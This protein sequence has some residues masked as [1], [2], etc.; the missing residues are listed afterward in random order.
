[1]ARDYFEFEADGY[2]QGKI[3]WSSSTNGPIQNSSNV[4]A[5]LYA[6]RTNS[7]TTKGR[8]WSGFVKINSAQSNISF[9][10]S[11]SVGSDWVEMTRV[12]TVVRHEDTGAGSAIISGSV[13]GPTETTLE[14]KTSSGKDTVTLDNILRYATGVTTTVIEFD[15][16]TAKIKWRADNVC[17][18]I[19][20]GLSSSNMTEY[21]VDSNTG[22][23]DLSGLS[24]DT[25][26]TL[27]FNAKRKDSELYLPDNVTLKFKTQPIARLT[28]VPN[29][30]IGPPIVVDPSYN[31]QQIIEWTN[32]SGANL[33]L[34]LC[35][36]DDT[37]IE[38]FGVV[39]GTTVT[40]SPNDTTILNLTPNSNVYKAKYV[41]TSVQ[42]EQTYTDEKECNFIVINSNPSFNSAILPYGGVDYVD[43]NET[44]LALTGKNTRLIKGYSNAK[45]ETYRD[46]FFA[47]NGA[48]LTD[49]NANL[50]LL[51]GGK[52]YVVPYV[53]AK[54]ITV[55]NIE[56]REGTITVKDSRGNTYT[57]DWITRQPGY[58][59]AGNYTFYEYF[60]LRIIGGEVHRTAGISKE[61]TLEFN[62]EWWNDSF[63]TTN[64][65]L[66]SVT[67]KFREVGIENY[68]SPI[69]ITPTI[70][71]NTF[72]FSDT[73]RGD[74]GTSGA[75]GFNV[76]KSYDIIIKV[77]DKLSSA[78]FQVLLIS[79]TPAFAIANGNKVAQGAAYDTSLGGDFQMNGTV[80]LNGEPLLSGGDI[81]DSL[82]STD[83][84]KVLS[85]NQGKILNE[86]IEG[87]VPQIITGYINR[88]RYTVS[89]S[90]SAVN[91]APFDSYVSTTNKISAVSNGF[92]IGSG[93][94][95]ILVSATC[96]GIDHSA[97]PRR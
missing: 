78:E 11:V 4:E 3:E 18:K 71:G 86:K 70:S 64:N 21:S 34:K 54:Y 75:E 79:G 35:K 88:K 7:A 73:I 19:K 40:V 2:L 92:K 38:D 9:D 65:A 85:A 27:Y 47:R 20:Y 91:L 32:P 5:V 72:S 74:Q 31:P 48:N 67:Y 44:T 89:Q 29:L 93:V 25:E 55:K 1:M 77:Q 61:T 63:G 36:L 58:D 42:N 17:S 84:T 30:E 49:N 23:F 66:D 50:T 16:N 41:L 12:S 97:F 28:S 76:S 96:R 43:V 39:T 57:R 22:N 87:Y 6:R 26:Y 81:E 56:T 80:Y 45:F 10:T 51:C 62:G 46:G 59:P 24:P 69:S 14:Y 8:S 53:D 15:L 95:K 33:S 37:L 60:P 90:W 82:T 94:S 68:S 83:A 13:T 52:S